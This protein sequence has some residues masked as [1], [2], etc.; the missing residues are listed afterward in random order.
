MYCKLPKIQL[1]ANDIIYPTSTYIRKY[2]CKEAGSFGSYFVKETLNIGN[3]IVWL[4]PHIHT[5]EKLQ[6][7]KIK[8]S[9]PETS[10]ANS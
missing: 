10:V 4:A 8:V 1:K 2:I 9:S 6:S 3:T 7:K 5:F